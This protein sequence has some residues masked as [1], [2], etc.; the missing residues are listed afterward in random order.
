MKTWD[1]LDN[2]I[3]SLTD[4]EKEQCNIMA[5]LYMVL[6]ES[7]YTERELEKITCMKQPAINRL[8]QSGVDHPQVVTLLNLLLPLGYTLKIVKKD[9]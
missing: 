8:K 5:H 6:K 2:Q 1:K 3:T 9:K 7:G 4:A